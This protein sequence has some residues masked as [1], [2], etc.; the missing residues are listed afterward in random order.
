MGELLKVTG[1]LRGGA[2]AR[3]ERGLDSQ[4]RALSTSTLMRQLVF[5]RN[6]VRGEKGAL[7]AVLTTRLPSPPSGPGQASPAEKVGTSEWSPS[8]LHP[9]MDWSVPFEGIHVFGGVQFSR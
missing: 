7:W 1:P 5:C 6:R 8:L 2:G 3:T 4:L 9:R